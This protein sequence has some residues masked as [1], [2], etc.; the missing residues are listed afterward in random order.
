MIGPGVPHLVA[1]C[2]TEPARSVA[3]GVGILTL[4]FSRT[5]IKVPTLSLQKAEGQGWGTRMG[6]TY[7]A[8]PSAWVTAPIAT[9]WS[10]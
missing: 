5:E 7:W 8:K 1:V 10:I 2:A 9:V 6:R 3:E 4:N